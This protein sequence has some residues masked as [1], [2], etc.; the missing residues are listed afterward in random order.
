MIMFFYIIKQPYFL[1]A[2]SLYIYK[3]KHVLITLDVQS[4]QG[5]VNVPA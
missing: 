1:L 2:A 4:N 5:I 3:K